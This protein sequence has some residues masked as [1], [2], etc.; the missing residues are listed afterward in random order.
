MYPS[1]KSVILYHKRY[2]KDVVF[3]L[4]GTISGIM[5]WIQEE[6]SKIQVP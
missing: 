5:D 4:L 6:M 1:K 3:D 2:A